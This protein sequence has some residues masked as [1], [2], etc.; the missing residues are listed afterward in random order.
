MYE[1]NN[2]ESYIHKYTFKCDTDTAVSI[3]L[4]QF[5]IIIHH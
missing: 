4:L 3:I 2:I 1:Y 5:T